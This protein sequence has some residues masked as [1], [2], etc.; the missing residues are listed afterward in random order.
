MRH[1]QGT[2]A[3][4]NFTAGTAGYSLD[5]ADGSIE[6]QHVT[7]NGGLH[8]ATIT[9]GEMSIGEHFFVTASSSSGTD[10]VFGVGEH[11]GVKTQ[12]SSG[13]YSLAGTALTT[14]ASG[15]GG[16]PFQ[17]NKNGALT[18]TG[19]TMDSVSLT[20]IQTASESFVDNDTSL[21]T[22]AAIQDKIESYGYSTTTGDITGV[23]AGSG[24][25]GGGSSGDV[26]LAV[27]DLAVSHFAGATIQTGSETFV[28]NDTSVMTSAA[29]QDKIQAEM[30]YTWTDYTPSCSWPVTVNQASYIQMGKIVFYKIQLTLTGTP[31]TSTFEVE[32]PVAHE[33]GQA[34]SGTMG[35]A[36]LKDVSADET[37]IGTVY[38]SGDDFRIAIFDEPQGTT[39]SWNDGLTKTRIF[40]WTTDDQIRMSGFYE[41]D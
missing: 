17:V 39:S 19:I 34:V 5:A 24:L 38:M 21:M 26:S 23:T 12:S 3:S 18:T 16:G 35:T 33:S 6:V 14:A 1:V 30:A 8:G 25:S 28:D 40:T 20:T 22:S 9:G 4:S 15:A 32:Q 31:S 27:A 11:T 36:Y 10:V 7:S 29:V 37:Y 2:I 41:V 13:D